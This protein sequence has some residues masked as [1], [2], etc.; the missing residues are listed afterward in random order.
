MNWNSNTDSTS[1]NTVVEKMLLKK[2]LFEVATSPDALA[3]GG[4]VRRRDP[5]R[6][7]R[8]VVDEATPV[9]EQQAEHEHPDETRDAEPGQARHDLVEGPRRQQ[10]DHCDQQQHDDRG[11][12]PGVPVIDPVESVNHELAPWKPPASDADDPRRDL[13][14]S[15]SGTSN[16]MIRTDAITSGSRTPSSR[17]TGG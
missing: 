10:R 1:G 5:A 15:T 14:S 17:G 3:G 8:K 13:A 11:D 6:V 16:A 9:G 2:L 7:V 4:D 12:E